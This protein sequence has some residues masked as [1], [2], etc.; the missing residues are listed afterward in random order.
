MISYA[1]KSEIKTAEKAIK[2][3]DYTS[4][5]SAINAAEALIANA[6]EIG[7]AHV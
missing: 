4:A 2:K 1:Q 7:R 5:V 6:D 3:Q